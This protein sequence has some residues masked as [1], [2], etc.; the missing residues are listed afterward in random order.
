M[1]GPVIEELPVMRSL[2]PS[3]VFGEPIEIDFSQTLIQDPSKVVQIT[4]SQMSVSSPEKSR[5]RKKQSK[6]VSTQI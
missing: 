5:K 1:E 2:S 6:K 4:P 3:T